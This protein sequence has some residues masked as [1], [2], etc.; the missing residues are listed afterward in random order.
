MSRSSQTIIVINIKGSEKAIEGSRDM[1]TSVKEALQSQ[2]PKLKI[3]ATQF[4]GDAVQPVLMF[5]TRFT[6]SKSAPKA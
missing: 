5:P 3:E 2:F 6:E 1:I 4:S